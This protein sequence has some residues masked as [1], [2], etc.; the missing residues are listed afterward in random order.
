MVSITLDL[1]FHKS[2][3]LLYRLFSVKIFI[4]FLGDGEKLDIQ[5]LLHFD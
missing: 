5:F 2:I 3:V 4:D 1:V